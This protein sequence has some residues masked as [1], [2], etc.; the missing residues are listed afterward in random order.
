M[1]VIKVC[2]RSLDYS[3]PGYCRCLPDQTL[4]WFGRQLP[5]STVPTSLKPKSS[6]NTRA[7]VLMAKSLP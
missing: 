4:A 5:V 3:S 7:A 2:S 1:V 6:E